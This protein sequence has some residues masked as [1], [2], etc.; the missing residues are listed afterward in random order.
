[1]IEYVGM[2]QGYFIRWALEKCG[3]DVTVRKTCYKL[4]MEP[5][6]LCESAKHMKGETRNQTGKNNQDVSEK[7]EI[8]KNAGRNP[9]ICNVNDEEIRKVGAQSTQY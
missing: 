2:E 6:Y 5:C 7:Q 8:G 1:M 3:D 4:S 9:K